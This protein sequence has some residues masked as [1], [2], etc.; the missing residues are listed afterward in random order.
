MRK[1]NLQA[2]PPGEA[3]SGHG[4]ALTADEHQAGDLTGYG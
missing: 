3:L 1:S 2:L 4:Q